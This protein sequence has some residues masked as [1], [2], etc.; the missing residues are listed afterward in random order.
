MNYGLFFVHRLV[1]SAHQADFL[2]VQRKWPWCPS[3]TLWT[4]WTCVLPKNLPIE[5]AS[6]QVQWSPYIW[7][8][9]KFPSDLYC[10]PRTFVATHSL[11]WMFP[12]RLICSVVGWLKPK[13]AHMT[14]MTSFFFTSSFSSATAPICISLTVEWFSLSEFYWTNICSLHCLCSFAYRVIFIVLS[15]ALYGLEIIWNN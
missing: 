11:H 4:L 14:D 6:L 5:H 13:S 12:E 10:G 7:M 1:K 2:E 8:Q 3:Q 15:G 9:S